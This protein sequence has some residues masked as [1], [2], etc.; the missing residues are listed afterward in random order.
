M[1]K[2]TGQKTVVLLMASDGDGVEDEPAKKRFVLPCHKADSDS[3]NNDDSGV[4]HDK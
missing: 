4:I 3:N 2:A 1:H